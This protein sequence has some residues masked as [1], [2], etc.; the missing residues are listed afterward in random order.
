MRVTDTAGL[1]E[2][3]AGDKVEREG[4]KRAVEEA[5]RSNARIVLLDVLELDRI[6]DDTFKLTP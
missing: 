1:R 5:K 6:S 2:D 3:T 4:I